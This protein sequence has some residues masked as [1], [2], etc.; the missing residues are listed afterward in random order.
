MNA[1]RV[2][3]APKSLYINVAPLVEIMLVLIIIFMITVPVLNVGVPVDLPKTKAAALNDTKTPPIVVSIDKG[4]KIYVEEA[5]IS[6]DDLIRKLPAILEN[7]KSD[8]VYVRGDKD[9]PYGAIMEIMGIISS[10]GACKVSL[11]SEV[12]NSSGAYISKGTPAKPLKPM[13]AKE[14]KSR[15]KR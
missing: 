11:I 15:K 10:T 1:R 4:S 3:R 7:G 2:R 12:D 5:E 14:K 9:L 8:T 13:P 6:L